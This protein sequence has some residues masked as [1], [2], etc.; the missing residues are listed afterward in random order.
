MS[1]YNISSN[2]TDFV[3]W[4]NETTSNICA[5]VSNSAT[6]GSWIFFDMFLVVSWLILFIAFKRKSNFKDSY[7]GSSFIIIIFGIILFV[8]PYNFIRSTELIFLLI[9]FFISM[10]VLYLKK[11]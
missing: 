5:D 9:N 8:M 2:I 1:L 10:M 7:A 11:D 4:M 6:C 3:G